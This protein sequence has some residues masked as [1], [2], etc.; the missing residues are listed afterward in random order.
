MNTYRTE[1]QGGSGV[2]K[3]KGFYKNEPHRCEETSPALALRPCLTWQ[4]LGMG[5]FGHVESGIA[6][7]MTY[8]LCSPGFIPEGFIPT[9]QVQGP[10]KICFFFVYVLKSCLYD[11]LQSNELIDL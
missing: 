2:L 1:T 8:I 3:C 9:L 5:G 4:Q 11:Q 10:S 6:T 7:W